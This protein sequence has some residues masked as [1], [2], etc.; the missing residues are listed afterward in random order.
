MLCLLSFATAT[1][2]LA[3]DAKA[4]A[5]RAQLFR[6]GYVIRGLLL[7]R[8]YEHEIEQALEAGRLIRTSQ[9]RANVLS[10]IGWGLEFRF[11]QDGSL[12]P[13]EYTLAALSGKERTRVLSGMLWS[14]RT[15]IRQL[16][17]REGTEREGPGDLVVRERLA[18]LETFA[19]ARLADP[20]A[21][22]RSPDRSE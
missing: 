15:R 13:I 14:A 5:G 1:T 21:I 17:E 11:E 22:R 10:G 3:T 20:R 6:R 7:H 18:R 8:K 12:E 19:E 9:H 4:G 16:G 2:F